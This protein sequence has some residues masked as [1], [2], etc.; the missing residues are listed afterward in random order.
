MSPKNPSLGGQILYTPTPPPLKIP[1]WGWG[2]GKGFKYHVAKEGGG[3]QG[4]YNLPPEGS[5][6]VRLGKEQV[7]TH[8]KDFLE[9]LIP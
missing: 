9:V 4:A 1:F 8:L 7:T 5:H 3:E 6:M 2:G